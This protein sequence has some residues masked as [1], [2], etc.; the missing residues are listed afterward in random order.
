MLR[1][2]QE[3]KRVAFT[4]YDA[5]LER[6]IGFT[7]RQR[8]RLHAKGFRHFD[9]DDGSRRADLNARQIPDGTDRLFN[10][11]EIPVAVFAVHDR[12]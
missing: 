3:R 1:V 5:F 10:A 7:P 9:L 12:F 2:E 6:G 8:F 11:E 4:L